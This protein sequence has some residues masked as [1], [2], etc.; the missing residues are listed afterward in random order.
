MTTTLIKQP[1]EHCHALE[2]LYPTAWAECSELQ[3]RP[4]AEALER[5]L[6]GV[7]CFPRAEILDREYEPRAGLILVPSDDMHVGPCATVHWGYCDPKYRNAGLYQPL[8]REAFRLAG[9][10]LLPYVLYT[11]RVGEGQYL[12]TYRRVQNGRSS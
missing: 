8:L 1:G 5:V 10:W 3:A 12:A 11:R 6:A 2:H 4:L 9:Q 7:E